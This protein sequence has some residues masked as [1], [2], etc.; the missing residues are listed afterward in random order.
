MKSAQYGSLA[1]KTIAAV[2]VVLFVATG[3]TASASPEVDPQDVELVLGRRT[4][5]NNC[6]ACHGATG[7]GGIGNQINTREILELYPTIEDQ[8]EIVTDGRNRMPS[9]GA[10]LSEEEIDAVVRYS[11]ETLIEAALAEVAN[12]S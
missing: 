12:E 4:Y 9:F 2:L 6:V 7:D 3:C 8:I 10:R 5:V 1:F 11:R